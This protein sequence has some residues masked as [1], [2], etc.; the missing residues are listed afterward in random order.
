MQD[1]STP[2]LAPAEAALAPPPFAL[3]R[4][5]VLVGLMGA[6][7]TSIGKRLAQR[8]TVPFIDADA[9]IESA[10]GC[11]IDEIFTRHGEQAFRDGERKVIARLLASPDP[12][13]LATGGGAF[14]DP[15]TRARIKESGLSVWLRADL[16]VLL[17]RVRK[18]GNRPLLRNGDPQEVLRRLIDT[19]YPVYGQAD[20][21]VDSVDGPHEAVVERVLDTVAGHLS[22]GEPHP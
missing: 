6:G 21:V 9:E 10:A 5:L 17:R 11:T 20:L 4:S 15:E 2:P 7:K 3:S 8:L 22:K 1:Q 14:M 18:R 12:C 19:R 13:V 16:D